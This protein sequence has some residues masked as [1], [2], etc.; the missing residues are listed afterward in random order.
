MILLV[1]S[2]ILYMASILLFKRKEV[3]WLSVIVAV[4]SVGATILDQ[5]LADNELILMIIPVIFVLLM[6]GLRVMGLMEKW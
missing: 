5:T 1:A 4:C 3:A 6:S 2:I